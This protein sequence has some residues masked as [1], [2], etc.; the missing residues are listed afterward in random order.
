MRTEEHTST[1]AKILYRPVGLAGS[2]VAGVVAGQVFK[3]VWKRASAGEGA[4]APKALESE[5]PM[6]EVLLAAAVQG[7]IFATVKAA[8]DRNGARLFQRWTGEWPGN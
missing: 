2:I 8:V 6:G 5:Y 1:S 4:D 3:Q 7:A